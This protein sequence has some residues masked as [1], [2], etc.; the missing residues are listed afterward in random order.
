MPNPNRRPSQEEL[1]MSTPGRRMRRAPRLLTLAA[2]ALCIAPATPA[3][4]TPQTTVDA[5]L[6][7]SITL[8]I[9]LYPG[10]TMEPRHQVV[11]SHGPNG[12][13][14]CTGTVNGRPV[15]GPGHF[16][17]ALHGV[18]SCA[19]AV[20]TGIFVLKVPTTAGMQTIAGQ[21]TETGIAPLPATLAGGLTGTVVSGVALQGDCVTTPLTRAQPVIAV[22]VT[23]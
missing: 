7:C 9:N 19:E 20:F 4:A 6:T 5:D 13:A 14:V 18:G 12:T 1:M 3:A 16:G 23:T 22:T 11:T 21:F 2:A 17:D 8:T 10:L 15:T